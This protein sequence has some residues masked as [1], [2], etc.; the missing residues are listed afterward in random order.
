MKSFAL[1]SALVF[2]LL[3]M[4]ILPFSGF[5][6]FSYVPN[7]QVLGVSTSEM[8]KERSISILKQLDYTLN[9]G[10]DVNIFYDLIP[11]EYRNS[12]NLVVLPNEYRD[13]G[14]VASIDDKGLLT[15]NRPTNTKEINKIE[16]TILILN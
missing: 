14:I 12:K 2:A 15:I 4:F 10:E 9:L 1:N 11:E 5:G 6:M 3:A 8:P 13:L 7:N 16:L